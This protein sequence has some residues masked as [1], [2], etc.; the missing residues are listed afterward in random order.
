MQILIWAGA[1]LAAFGLVGVLISLM[2]AYRLKSSPLS[3]EENAPKFRTV[4]MVNAMAM[5]LFFLGAMVA[6]LGILL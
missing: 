3:A 6:V 1:G 5:G 4:Y 2:M